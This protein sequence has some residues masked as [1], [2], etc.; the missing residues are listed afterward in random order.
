[1]FLLLTMLLLNNKHYKK[2]KNK[3]ISNNDLN[4]LFYK[5]KKIQKINKCF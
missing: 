5:S 1:M 4:V 3:P 2:E